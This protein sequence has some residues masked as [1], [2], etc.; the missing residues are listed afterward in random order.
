MNVCHH[1]VVQYNTIVG[2]VSDDDVAAD[3]LHVLLQR[4]EVS[5]DGVVDLQVV[6]TGREVRDGVVAK[7]HRAVRSRENEGVVAISAG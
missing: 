3:L 4:S 5:K 1:C 2:I 6:L 7:I